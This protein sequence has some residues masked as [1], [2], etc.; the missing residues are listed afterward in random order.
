QT[1]S[2][3]AQVLD[4]MS[5]V[6]YEEAGKQAVERAKVDYFNNYQISDE[7]IALAKNAARVLAARGIRVNTLS[8]GATDTPMIASAP[9]STVAF[10]STLVAR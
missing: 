9:A 8:P 5:G 10:S 6:L 7:Q 4:R 2:A 1:S 3:L